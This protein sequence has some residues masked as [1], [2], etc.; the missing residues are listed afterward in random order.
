MYTRIEKEA[1][2]PARKRGESGGI[3][4]RATARK[5]HWWR[6][7]WAHNITVENDT[8]KLRY[9]FARIQW[10][11]LLQAHQFTQGENQKNDSTLERAQSPEPGLSR[12]RDQPRKR[13]ATVQPTNPT[14][15]RGDPRCAGFTLDHLPKQATCAQVAIPIWLSNRS[16]SIFFKGQCFERNY[17]IVFQISFSRMEKKLTRSIT[18]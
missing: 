2:Q 5:Q 4:K 8:R 12:T 14:S 18:V 16:K 7:R 10:Q 11:N 17:I 13:S 3:K 1:S 6:I 9:S 15:G